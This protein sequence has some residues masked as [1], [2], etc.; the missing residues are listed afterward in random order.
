MHMS[1]FIKLVFASLL[2]VLILFGI[3]NAMEQEYPSRPIS[4]IIPT[5]PGGVTDITGRI[6]AE[7]LSQSLGQPVVPI[8]KPGGGA[9]IGGNAVVTSR[10]DGYTIGIF[11][12]PPAIPE[13]YRYFQE[14]PYSSSDLKPICKLVN[15]VGIVVV[16][17]DAPWNTLKAVVE[18][19]RTNPGMKFGITYIGGSPHCVMFAISKKE[20]ISFTAVPHTGDSDVVMS[21]L[22]GH[23]PIGLVAYTSGKVQVD[24]G[25]LK[26]LAMYSEKR[27]EL[28]PQVPTVGELGYI[29]SHYPC[30][31]LFGPKGTPDLVVQKISEKV[32][33]MNEIDLYRQKFISLGLQFAFESSD[34]YR[35]T[36][37]RYKTDIWDFFKELGYV[38]K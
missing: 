32:K 17:S 31:G 21:I 35:N 20:G 5:A 27:L 14:A 28:L 37:N 22:G 29:P 2:F 6:V 1:N 24:A 11:N 4:L 3:P 34:Q 36:L 9:L 18:H 13:I 33:K 38:K 19:V 25:S 26:I 23:I 30:L 12:P 15:F 10:P 16:K 8:N 7:Y